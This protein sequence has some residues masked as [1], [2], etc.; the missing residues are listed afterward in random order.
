M[1]T[2]IPWHRLKSVIEP[3]YPKA[4]NGRR[5][6]DPLTTTLRIHCIQQWYSMSDHEMEN[7]LYEIASM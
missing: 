3:Y 5:P 7:A 4:G 6:P 1:E 2:L